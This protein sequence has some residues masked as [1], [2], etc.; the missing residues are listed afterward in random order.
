VAAADHA[1]QEAFD[2]FRAVAATEELSPEDLESLSDVAFW[3]GHVS[4]AID[5]RQRAFAALEGAGRAPDA[6]AAA[7][8]ISLAHFGR[9]DTSVASGWLG[10]AQ[11]LLADAPESAAHALLAWVEG[12]LM[13]RL[14]GYEEALGKAREVELIAA[15]VGDRDLV[16]M[17]ISLQGFLRTLT[18]DVTGGLS[19]MDEALASALAGELGPL[20]TAEVFC[21]MVV[22]C[23]DAADFQ[24]AA[25]WLDTAERSGRQLVCFPGCCRVHRATVLRHRGEWPEAHRQARQARAEVAGVEVLHEGMALTELGEL[26][27]YKGETVLAEQA[28]SEAYEKGWPPQPGMA[29]LRLRA[30]DVHG[31]T[32]VIG[33]AV[34]WSADE[35][36]ALVR[37]LPAQVEIAI[38]AGDKEVVEAAAARLA[39]VSS[40]LGSTTAAAANA[41]VL[42]LLAQQHADLTEAAHQLELSVRGWQQVRN[43]YETAQAR[44]RRAS[45][46]AELGDLP[47]ATLELTAARKTFERLGATPDAREA[48]R[49][50]GDDALIH[51]TRAFMF[52]DIVN[53][54]SLLSAFGDE[55]WDGIR[56]WHDR[57]VSTIIAAHQGTIVKGMGDGFFAVFDEPALAVDSAIA[58]QRALDDHRGREGFSP[59]VRIGMHAGS[60]ITAADDYS[61]QDVV[62]AARI[63]ALAEADEILVSAAVVDRLG[64][65]VTIARRRP[66]ELKGIPAAVEIAAVEW[67]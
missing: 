55:T 46:L 27:R 6:G 34:E 39:E 3:A 57:T 14:K 32:S 35:P 38:A 62:V 5:A 21:E 58:I 22:S 25:E 44:M 63:S 45:V 50:L 2:G 49:R 37:L 8:M 48:A 13:G 66:A 52:T 47:S 30:G 36:P 41:S 12:Q 19:L 67:R 23:I 15:R 28:F 42:G 56:R 54:T 18:G 11:R 26:H 16:A 31:A 4:E 53:S 59:G 43:P 29:L 1:W 9:G 7:L 51:A 33:R 64:R 61:G 40:T 60:A 20:A 65:H 17:G 24:R 10:R